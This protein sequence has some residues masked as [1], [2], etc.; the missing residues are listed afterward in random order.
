MELIVA[1]L[2]AAAG[3]LV[4]HFGVLVPDRLRG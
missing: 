1:S 4:A 3:L 2:I